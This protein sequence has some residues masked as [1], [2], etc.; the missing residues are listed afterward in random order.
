M[1]PFAWLKVIVVSCQHRID[2]PVF[3]IVVDIQLT[4]DKLTVYN[5]SIILPSS[6]HT[7]VSN[8]RIED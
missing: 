8:S 6:H 7:E 1:H 2:N 3:C 5:W 4:A